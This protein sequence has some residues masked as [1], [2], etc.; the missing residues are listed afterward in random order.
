MFL[1]AYYAIRCKNRPSPGLG[2]FLF[3]LISNARKA[4]VSSILLFFCA[5]LLVSGGIIEKIMSDLSSLESFAG[6][7]TSSDEDYTQKKTL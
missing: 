6:T 7:H 4:D 3:S 1:V 2:R 5:F